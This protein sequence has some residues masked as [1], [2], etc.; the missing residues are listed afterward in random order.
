MS[1]EVITDVEAIPFDK[2]NS[3]T[4]LE[5]SE[6]ETEQQMRRRIKHSS[7]Y[8]V[9]NVEHLD[10]VKRQLKQRHIQM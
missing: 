6:K 7:Q 9:L 5:Q 1:S 4:S 2:D 3:S 8:P 10:L